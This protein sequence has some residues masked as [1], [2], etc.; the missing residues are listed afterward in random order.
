MTAGRWIWTVIVAAVMLAASQDV[1]AQEKRIALLIGNKDYKPGVGALV[2]PLND[3]RVVGDALKAVGFEVMNPVTNAT[4]DSILLAVHDFAAKLKDAGKDAVGFLYY[5]G[6]GI[7]SGGD[8]FMIPVDVDEPSTRLLSVRGVKH[9]EVLAILRGEAP[10]AAHY[11]VLDAC[12]NNLQGAR[13]GKGF[14]PV[15]QQSGVLFAFSAEPGKTASDLGQGS[16]PYAAAL[17]AEL[18]K[19]GQD[20]LRMFHNVRVAV[21]D[22]TGGDQVPWTEDGI[23]RRERVMFG[24][25]ASQGDAAAVWDTIKETSNIGDLEAYAGRFQKT[26]FADL[27]RARIR[28][29][30]SG[31]IHVWSFI[32]VDDNCKVLELPRV[33]VL[34][35][36]QL[37]RVSMERRQAAVT[38]PL[39]SGVRH[40][41]GVKGEGITVSYDARSG[42]TTGTDTIVFRVEYVNT[43]WMHEFEVDLAKRSARRVRV[44]QVA[45]A[46]PSGT[47]RAQTAM[48]APPA[49]APEPAPKSVAPPPTPASTARPSACDGIDVTLGSGGTA[50]VKPGSGQTFRDCP[51][52]PEMVV[53]P[54]GS[55]MMGSPASEPQRGSDEGPQRRVTLAKPF[56]VGK[57]EVTFAEW[58]AC[59]AASGCKHKPETDWGRGR[60]P[61]MRVSWDDAKEYVAWLSRKAGKPYRLLS[62]AEWEYAARAGTTPPFWWG[63]SI[64]PSQ[65]NYDGSADP[66]KGGGSQGEYRQR[67]VVVDSFAANPWGLHNVHGNVW[68]WTEDC[69]HDSYNG[70]PSDGSA[71]TTSCTD[72]S[73]RVLRG[74]SWSHYPRSLRSANRNWDATVDRSYSRGFRVGRTLSP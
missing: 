67:T 57:F 15:G 27:A 73:R 7:A 1:H 13:G 65:A 2:N 29:L 16:G 8:N 35:Q 24:G 17:A 60:Q 36:P 45:G 39:G 55:F 46:Q 59:V 23:Q 9:T 11:I 4:R 20:D 42:T 38:Q 37:G 30:S 72:G 71:W 18:K 5:S 64:M 33:E 31:S 26:V 62:E 32:S 52:C 21:I 3:V 51:D 68:E 10:N 74:G 49:K 40:C 69:W 63:S 53:V 50:C 19:P 12:R 14:V 6:H 48:V 34:Q 28:E 61:V 66:Y 44:T 56:G 70:A 54:A 58:D 25:G 47:G 22:K 43:K 41:L